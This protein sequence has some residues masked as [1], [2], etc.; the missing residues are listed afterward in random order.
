[1]KREKNPL[2]R[3][4]IRPVAVLA[5]GLLVITGLLL[6]HAPAR[7]A[8]GPGPLLLATG[9]D[10][11][12]GGVMLGGF[13]TEARVDLYFHP[14][15]V[16]GET[17]GDPGA[18][19]PDVGEDALAKT[20]LLPPGTR[21]VFYALDG[22]VVGSGVSGDIGFMCLDAS[23]QVFLEP[24]LTGVKSNAG[25]YEGI[26]IGMREDMEFAAV[27]TVRTDGSD[28][29]FTLAPE[30]GDVSILFKKI[31]Q[32]GEE[33]FSGILRQGGEEREIFQVP[34]EEIGE[35]AAAFIDLNADGVLEFLR[36]NEGPAGSVGVYEASFL[37]EDNLLFLL[38]T[39]E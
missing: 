8:E 16:G 24:K 9:W 13:D 26:V 1:M 11:E 15:H 31:T 30:K 39:G 35:M 14:I 38:D 18:G 20:D 19:C 36:I 23:G 5:A 32:D 29:S 25:E 37:G 2:S 22:T 33:L 27:P 7:A 34:A 21:L 17:L 28:G 4:V 10:G 12:S 6:S 3:Q